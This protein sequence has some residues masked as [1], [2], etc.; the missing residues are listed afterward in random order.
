MAASALLGLESNA[1]AIAIE[2]T[3]VDGLFASF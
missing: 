3:T 2:A 1:K